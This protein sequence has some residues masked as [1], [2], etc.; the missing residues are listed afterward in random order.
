[1]NYIFKLIVF[2]GIVLLFPLCVA[3]MQSKVI[4]PSSFSDHYQ[5]LDQE[6][7]IFNTDQSYSLQEVIKEYPDHFE[8]Y[9]KE[10]S[11]RERK[12]YWVKITLKTSFLRGRNW[13]FELNHNHS[14]LEVYGKT[15]SDS[16]F[17]I[18][19]LSTVQTLYSSLFKEHSVFLLDKLNSI[20]E[21]T[22]VDLY[23]H[24]TNS[25]NKELSFQLVSD[26]AFFK[27]SN[28]L[29]FLSGLKYGVLGI[30][31]L[32][33]VVWSI[34]IDKKKVLFFVFLLGLFTL[35]LSSNIYSIQHLFEVE[36]QQVLLIH[37]MLVIFHITLILTIIPNIYKCN[38][39]QFHLLHFVAL[40]FVTAFLYQSL[41]NHYFENIWHQYIVL[42][43]IVIVIPLVSLYNY[44]L[45]TLKTADTIS[46]VLLFVTLIFGISRENI[47]SFKASCSQDS[48]HFLLLIITILISIYQ[49]KID[50]NV[51]TQRNENVKK[52]VYQPH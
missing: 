15:Q 12:E 31:F 16:T 19:N 22:V 18:T 40:W 23:L 7:A 36:Y 32:V 45:K 51:I 25:Y 47:S 1:M 29:H 20:K 42:L 11:L 41:G 33:S 5:I 17:F 35:F 43:P 50:H 6:V 2:Y 39:R 30:L 10:N 37:N 21:H 14:D 4:H 38:I 24:F 9:S 13:L 34:V 28:E 49:F 3:G 27:T 46:C 8:V 26:D 52:L 48:Y 44:F